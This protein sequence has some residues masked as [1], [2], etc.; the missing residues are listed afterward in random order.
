M[1]EHQAVREG[2]PHDEHGNPYLKDYGE[3]SV[4]CTCGKLS[5]PGNRTWRRH[6]MV[7]HRRMAE[8]AG[9]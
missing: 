1:S 4:L 2:W 5:P 8:A 3:G 7:A 6:W 9:R